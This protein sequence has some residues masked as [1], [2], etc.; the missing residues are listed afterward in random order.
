MAFFL[1]EAVPYGNC[2]WIP[3]RS[4]SSCSWAVRTWIDCMFGE[5]SGVRHFPTWVCYTVLHWASYEGFKGFKGGW[6]GVQ[7]V[8]A[9]QALQIFARWQA[10]DH[11]QGS[12]AFGKFPWQCSL[13]SLCGASMFAAWFGRC[14]SSE[15]VLWIWRQGGALQACFE[16][17]W[18]GF[19][20]LSGWS[21]PRWLLHPR[22]QLLQRCGK[23]SSDWRPETGEQA[24]VPLGGAK[25]AKWAAVG[26]SVIQEVEGKSPWQRDGSSRLLLPSAGI[27][28]E[29]SYKCPPLPFSPQTQS[30][31]R[32]YGF[33]GLC[34][35]VWGWEEKWR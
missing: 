33:Q 31:R 30:F 3:L 21:L 28:G 4:S 14:S 34:E 26:E 11:W 12:V 24:W 9:T 17:G 6:G 27:A 15:P 23:W 8:P 10:E 20:S 29:I 19:T 5:T 35:S 16:M 22:V 25:A 13:S 18:A 7:Q 2:V 1:W 32:Y